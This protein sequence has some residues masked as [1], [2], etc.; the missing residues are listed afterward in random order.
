M[1]DNQ[2]LG[3]R[4]VKILCDGRLVCIFVFALCM[5]SSTKVLAFQQRHEAVTVH[6]DLNGT[7]YGA[8]TASGRN[9]QEL[10]LSSIAEDESF[11]FQRWCNDFDVAVPINKPITYAHYVKLLVEMIWKN[12]SYERIKNEHLIKPIAMS[13][14]KKKL[15]DANNV[16]Q[17]MPKHY[18]DLSNRD[19]KNYERLFTNQ[20]LDAMRRAHHPRCEDVERMLAVMLE[21]DCDN[22]LFKSMRYFLTAHHRVG[23]PL[24]LVIRTF[25]SDVD[26]VIGKIEAH[27]CELVG[28]SVRLRVVKARCHYEGTQPVLTLESGRV[29][30]SVHEMAAFFSGFNLFDTDNPTVLFVQDNFGAWGTEKPNER[31][32]WGKPIPLGA[33][34]LYF[35]DHVKPYGSEYNICNVLHLNPDQDSKSIT[36]RHILKVVPHLANLDERYLVGLA[37]DFYEAL[38]IVF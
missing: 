37:R 32:M 11:A 3:N 18:S 20:L 38:G 14:A 33:R 4:Y 35:D 7:I 1:F 26:R 29:L 6:M 17:E 22:P 19:H 34:V 8:D 2:Q 13:A 36:D 28:H 25:G 21:N 24:S 30:S 15:K 12:K 9:E 16:L 10:Y 23:V 31:A 27:L 5:A